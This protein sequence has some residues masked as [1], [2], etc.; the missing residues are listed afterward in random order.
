MEVGKLGND[1]RLHRGFRQDQRGISGHVRL[2]HQQLYISIVELMLY[3][4]LGVQGIGVHHD[5]ACTKNTKDDDEV[6]DE[7]GHLNRNSI[8]LREA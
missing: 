3:L 4:S 1:Y 8:S 2:H 7:I 6:L 5:H